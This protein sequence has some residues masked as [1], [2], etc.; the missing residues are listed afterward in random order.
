MDTAGVDKKTDWCGEKAFDG[1]H[2]ERR[3]NKNKTQFF[4]SKRRKTNIFVPELSKERRKTNAFIPQ[5][6]KERR[7]TNLFVPKLHK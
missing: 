2:E 4:G 6:S 3:Q 5:L 7:K 1:E